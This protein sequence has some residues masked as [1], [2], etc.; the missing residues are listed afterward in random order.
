M[1]QQKTKDT[2]LVY[3]LGTSVI[4]FA[5]DASAQ[6]QREWTEHINRMEIYSRYIEEEI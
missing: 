6:D 1:Q 2:I 5:I 4:P 3:F